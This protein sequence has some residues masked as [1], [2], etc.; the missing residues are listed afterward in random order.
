MRIK[1]EF[2][3]DA[4]DSVTQDQIDQFIRFELHDINTIC[5]SN[6]LTDTPIEPIPG[7]LVW[8]YVP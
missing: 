5:G 7:S 6:P 4:M 2:V 8:Y 3:L 1:V